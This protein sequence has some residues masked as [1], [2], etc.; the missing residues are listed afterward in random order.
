MDLH[1]AE[2]VPDW[3]LFA[4]ERRNFWQRI[5]GKTKGIVTPANA[6]S[7]AGA[8]LWFDGLYDYTQGQKTSGILKMASGAIC[9]FFDGRVARNT[10]TKSPLGEVIDASFDKVKIIG[11]MIVFGLTDVIPMEAI[12]PMALQNAAN[13]ALTGIAK[14]RKQEVHTEFPNKLTP[15]AQV[16]MGMGGF[17][18]ADAL[19]PGTGQQ[20]AEVAGYVGAVGG[21][22]FPGIWGTTSI[23]QQA[24]KPQQLPEAA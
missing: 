2:K 16:G 10:G 13:I 9:D 17:V 14:F 6:V 24:F 12:V 4:P 23:A 7:F 5:A 19:A 22:V 11:G 20:I 21:S 1:R 8:G 3:E 18:L 15:W